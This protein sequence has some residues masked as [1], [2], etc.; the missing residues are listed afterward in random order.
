M[1]YAYDKWG[2]VTDTKRLLNSAVYDTT[3]TRY[4]GFGRVSN[5]TERFN[6]ATT[7]HIVTSFLYDNV[8]R[9][10]TRTNAIRGETETKVSGTEYGIFSGNGS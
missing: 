10:T 9:I 2:R 8:D 1:E 4:D 6:L 3:N 7:E 5:V